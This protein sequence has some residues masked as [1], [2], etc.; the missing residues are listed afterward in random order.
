MENCD[1]C[2]IQ[3]SLLAQSGFCAFYEEALDNYYTRQM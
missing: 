2:P 3:K 1:K